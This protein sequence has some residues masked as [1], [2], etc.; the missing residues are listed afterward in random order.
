MAQIQT[1]PITRMNLLDLISFGKSIVCN[2]DNLILDKKDFKPHYNK[3]KAALKDM[4]GCISNRI[5]SKITKQIDELG[6]KRNKIFSSI[7]NIIFSYINFND[8]STLLSYEK[9]FSLLNSLSKL[10]CLSY[11]QQTAII[12][13][14]I[15]D[16]KSDL[17]KN[18]IIKLNLTEWITLLDEINNEYIKL[19]NIR[20][21][22]KGIYNNMLKQTDAKKTFI[23]TY[24]VLVIRLNSL[25]V[26]NGDNQYINLFSCWNTLIDERKN[27]LTLHLGAGRISKPDCGKSNM[28]D[29]DYGPVNNDIT[30]Y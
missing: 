16:V 8:S 3:Y 17:Y 29:P 18:D 1:F 10:Y 13:K 5:D 25:A 23:S 4:E 6:K 12:S 9:L 27:Y 20:T 30:S 2:I 19:R 28:A 14:F 24:Y 7:R 26:V 21:D 15:N 11:F 22:K